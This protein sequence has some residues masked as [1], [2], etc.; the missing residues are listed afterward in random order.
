ME[1]SG[2]SRPRTLTCFRTKFSAAAVLFDREAKIDLGG[3]TARLFYI[4]PAHT[5]GDEL[6]F[7]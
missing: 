5:K 4:G 3:V 6:N 1:A 7:R 2:K